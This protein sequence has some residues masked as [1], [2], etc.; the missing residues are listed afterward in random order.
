LTFSTL[1]DARALE[2]E[3]P[4]RTLLPLPAELVTRLDPPEPPRSLL[5]APPED[6][7]LPVVPP[8][9]DCGT[10]ESTVLEGV[11]LEPPELT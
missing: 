5:I 6:P 11:E 8:E 4:P 1:S 9:V 2:P 10:L 7:A 3:V